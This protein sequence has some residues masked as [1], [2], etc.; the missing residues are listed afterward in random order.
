M[1]I[2]KV[3]CCNLLGLSSAQLLDPP[4]RPPQFLLRLWAPSALRVLLTLKLF[5]PCVHLG[6]G[7]LPTWQLLVIHVT[8]VNY[9]PFK[10]LV[11]ASSTLVWA[12]FVW[13]S[14]SFLSLSRIIAVSCSQ[15]SSSASLKIY[16]YI[17]LIQLKCWQVNMNLLGNGLVVWHLGLHHHLL[18]AGIQGGHLLLTLQLG[19]T[20]CLSK[21]ECT[22]IL[23]HLSLL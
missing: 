15:R 5:D 2:G 23:Y 18:Q 22:N 9:L 21:C 13:A 14:S 10:A 16:I 17:Y 1:C 7:F 4:L 3:Q 11:S 6:H 19:S 8:D 20:D 12:S